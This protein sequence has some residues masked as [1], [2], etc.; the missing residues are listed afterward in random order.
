MFI[1]IKTQSFGVSPETICTKTP[2]LLSLGGMCAC[3]IPH[4]GCKLSCSLVCRPL[5]SSSRRVL[6]A[7]SL[8][9]PGCATKPCRH[10]EEKEELQTPLLPNS[11]KVEGMKQMWMGVTPFASLKEY[12][13]A[14]ALW[15]MVDDDGLEA[16]VKFTEEKASSQNCAQD[17]VLQHYRDHILETMKK[18]SEEQKAAES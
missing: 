12:L 14:E 16:A 17:V 9:D 18:Y 10:F 15:K 5:H 8:E 4:L 2:T 1:T 13:K 3:H 6:A 11:K 7:M